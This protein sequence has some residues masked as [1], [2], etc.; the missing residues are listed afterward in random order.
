MMFSFV[1]IKG[2]NKSAHQDVFINNQLL[3]Q[4]WR[5]QIKL[6]AECQEFLVWRWFAKSP[7]MTAVLGHAVRHSVMNGA[8]FIS[9]EKAAEI[10]YAI[11]H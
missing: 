6:R 4:V 10:L 5:E 7:G 8:G 2:S 9:K 1:K 3:G 11:S